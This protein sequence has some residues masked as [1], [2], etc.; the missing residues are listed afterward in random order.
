MTLAKSEDVRVF[1]ASVLVG[2]WSTGDMHGV[3]ISTEQLLLGYYTGVCFS[4]ESRHMLSA[5]SVTPPEGTLYTVLE[6][7][8]LFFN[9]PAWTLHV[10]FPFL[11]QMNEFF[12]PL[13]LGPCLVERNQ[14]VKGKYFETLVLLGSL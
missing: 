12:F 9:F 6:Q 2:S 8:R 11:T 14:V 13:L 5:F 4:A 7:M 3:S 10:A 1:Q